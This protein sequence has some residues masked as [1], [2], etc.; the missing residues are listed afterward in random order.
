MGH[1]PEVTPLGVLS[2]LP[3]PQ[4]AP[5]SEGTFPTPK[6]QVKNPWYDLGGNTWAR[7][8]TWGG[9]RASRALSEL[10]EPGPGHG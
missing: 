2:I 7:P 5:A 1:K 3:G 8:V 10:S 9:Q 4:G 6:A